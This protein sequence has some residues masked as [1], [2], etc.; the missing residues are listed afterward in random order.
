MHK[1]VLGLVLTLLV[2]ACAT[3]PVIPV[4]PATAPGPDFL[5]RNAAAKDVVTTASGLQ[6][7]IIRSGPTTG[8]HPTGSD[9]V[10]FDYEGKLVTGETFDS[11]YERGTPLTG[12]VD[13]FVPG[14]TEA[15]MLMRPG[16]EWIVWI[17]PALGYGDRSA[18]PIPP[19]SILRFKL[20][21]HSVTP[22][23]VAGR[24]PEPN[25]LQLFNNRI[26]VAAAVN[27]VPVT[28]LLDSGAEMTVLDDDF[29]SRVGINASGGAAAKGSGAAVLQARFGQE[30][31]IDVAGL[32]MPH[33]TV[34]ILD[35]E[36]ISDRLVGRPVEVIVGR[37]VFDAARLRID[38]EGRHLAPVDR[39]EQPPG[40]SFALTAHRGI[41]TI[42][43]SVEGHPPSQGVFDLGNGSDLM[44]GR[45]YAEKLGLT[46]PERV[47]GQRKG[48]GIGGELVRDLVILTSLTIGS[49]TFRNVPAAIDASP[50]AADVNIGT[51]I[52]REFIITA[53][54]QQRTLWLAARDSGSGGG[55]LLLRD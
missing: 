8:S 31:T 9:T 6:Y 13:A 4:P 43:V 24:S 5:V 14:F 21:L 44:I 34:A 32:S 23:S 40:Q 2:S 45:S 33:R 22:A 47:A 15:L 28:A 29:A 55:Q 38:I 17:P 16:D 3:V 49:H 50:T 12:P 48:G 11:S 27:G 46:K 52:L 7:F 19:G 25:D 53:D 54:F 10:T 35:L 18:G 36:D 20:A 26:F 37:E 51:S 41:E 42:P 30:V 1:L 39:S